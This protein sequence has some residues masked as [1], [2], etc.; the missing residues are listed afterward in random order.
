M[1]SEC[2]GWQNPGENM[3]I[4]LLTRR[5]HSGDFISSE[6]EYKS[7]NNTLWEENRD[8]GRVG[9]KDSN[10]LRIGEFDAVI[11]LWAAWACQ[12]WQCHVNQTREVGE[13]R[14]LSPWKD[15]L[16]CRGVCGCVGHQGCRPQGRLIRT[17]HIWAQALKTGF[18]KRPSLPTHLSGEVRGQCPPTFL[19]HSLKS[20]KRN[21]PHLY[22]S[23][24]PSVLQL[25]LVLFLPSHD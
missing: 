6:G 9:C 15:R 23:Q 20:H 17:W 11:Q 4:C 1:N 18:G 22:P 5:T 14:G 3:E 21:H 10:P 12:L 16:Q 19:D 25:H 7:P 24:P 13:E 8:H 2:R